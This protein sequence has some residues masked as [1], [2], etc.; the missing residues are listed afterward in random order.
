MA[1]A[2][3]SVAGTVF[4]L[5][6]VAGLQVALRLREVPVP[7]LVG[8]SE[9]QAATTL[10]R[11]GLEVRVE[12]LPRIDPGIPAGHVADQDPATG[13]TTRSGRSVKVG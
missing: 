12:P 3:V 9:E 1:G 11:H 10:G 4:L 5:F 8:L 6:A 2:V 7:D 13:L